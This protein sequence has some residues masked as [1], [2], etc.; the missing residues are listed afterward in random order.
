MTRLLL[1][2]TL[3]MGLMTGVAAGKDNDKHDP[4]PVPEPS[5]V[6]PALALLTGTTLILRSRRKR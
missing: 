1:L 4:D 5:Q 3:V 6:V 2:G